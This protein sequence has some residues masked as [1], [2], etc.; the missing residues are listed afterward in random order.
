VLN[1]CIFFI[2]LIF[3]IR[4]NNGK[5]LF[6]SPFNNDEVRPYFITF[7]FYLMMAMT[8]PMLFNSYGMIVVVWYWSNI[9]RL[10]IGKANLI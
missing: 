5:W 3:P 10:S 7:I 8:N 1:T 6:I 2:I 9:Y 4:F